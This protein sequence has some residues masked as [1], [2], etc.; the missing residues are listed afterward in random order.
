MKE[1]RQQDGQQ[2]NPRH[3]LVGALVLVAL[4]VILV[5]LVLDFHAEQGQSSGRDAMLERPRD[6]RVEEVPLV[7]PGAVVPPPA[8]GGG[9]PAA[10]GAD[11]AAAA[12]AA[13]PGV[14][15]KPPA[16][17]VQVGS[18]AS[19]DN[20][21]ALR[22]QLRS[23]GFKAVFLDRDMISGKPAWR[24]RVGPEMERA[25]SE[26]VRDRLLQE[27]KLEGVVVSYDWRGAR[28]E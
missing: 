27:M 9:V 25:R 15:G 8:E 3:R 24:V 22:D 16:W 18:F 6:F 4:G 13:G 28:V 7:T 23:R 10:A 5:P 20:A 17:V 14:T 11:T 19:V 2:P 1:Y 26:Q 21:R 12:P